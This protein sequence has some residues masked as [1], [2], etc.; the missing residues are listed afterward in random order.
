ME[1]KAYIVG[2]KGDSEDCGGGQIKAVWNSDGFLGRKT[3]IKNCSYLFGI[4]EDK[5]C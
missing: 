4:L 5:L 1:R 3:L 2:L